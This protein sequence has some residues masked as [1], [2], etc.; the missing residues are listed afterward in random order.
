M[1]PKP[2]K[3]DLPETKVTPDPK[4][5]KRTRRVHSPEYKLKILQE[6][7]A[8][9][10]GELGPLLRREGLYSNQLK[11]WRE[12]FA[13]NGIDGLTKSAPG[14]AAKNTPEQ[15][16]IDKLK[17]ENARLAKELEISQECLGLQKK[18][19]NLIDLINNDEKP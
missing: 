14:P 9:K 18:A 6:A 5:E 16:E 19:L 15:R 11:Q 12:D 8:C 4:L 10:R 13:V 2:S 3:H 7:E 1:M 17:K